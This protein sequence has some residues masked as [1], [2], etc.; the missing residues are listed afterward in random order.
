MNAAANESAA[1][2]YN[3]TPKSTGQHGDGG[4]DQRRHDHGQAMIG[5]PFALRPAAG[6]TTKAPP[7]LPPPRPLVHRAA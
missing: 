5:I 4:R 3:T 7:D 1:L 6:A 2:L